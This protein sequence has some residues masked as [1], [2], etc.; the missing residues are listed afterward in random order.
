M[1]TNLRKRE[2]IWISTGKNRGPVEKPKEKR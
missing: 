1:D 2:N